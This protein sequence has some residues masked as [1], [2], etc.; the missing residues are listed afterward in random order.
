MCAT[1]LEEVLQ[2]LENLVQHGPRLRPDE[3][4]GEHELRQ[5]VDKDTE[6]GIPSACARTEWNCSP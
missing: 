5:W 4:D 3:T 2:K 6:A 1:S